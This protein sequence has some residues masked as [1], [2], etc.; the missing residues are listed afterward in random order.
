MTNPF[1]DSGFPFTDSRPADDFD[2]YVRQALTW[3][4]EATTLSNY[5]SGSVE[6]STAIAHV[7][8]TLA[9]AVATHHERNP[10]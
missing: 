4:K 8:A 2:T 10:Q 9:L 5:G 1:T 7:Y 3:L 6:E